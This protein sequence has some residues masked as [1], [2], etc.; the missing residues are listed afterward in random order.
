MVLA[1]RSAIWLKLTPSVD[2]CTSMCVSLLELSAQARSTSLPDTAV[3]TRPLGASG[4]T[5]FG[6]A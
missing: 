6:A 4:T 5:D 2:C 1:S 3:A